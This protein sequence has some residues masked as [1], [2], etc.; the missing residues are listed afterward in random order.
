MDAGRVVG[1]GLRVLAAI[2]S[3]AVLVTTGLGWAL[4]ER[5][6]SATVTSNVITRTTPVPKGE[7]F[8]AL[9]VGLDARTDAAGN[10]LPPEL[11]DALH[12]GPDEGQLHTD[13]MIL[14]HVP[15]GSDPAGAP[16][17]AISIPRDSYVP[18]AGGRPHK[19]NSAYRRGLDAAEKTLVA[20]GVTGRRAGPPGPRGGPASRS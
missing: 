20:Q 8:T 9:L 17:V 12:A 19:I 14:L 7:P 13:T 5:V 4:Q 15:G 10:Q 2:V 1:L 16:A 11:L 18:I 3:L 6:K